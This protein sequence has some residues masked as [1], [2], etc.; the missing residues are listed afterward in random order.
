[1]PKQIIWSPL[2]EGDFAMIL[3]YLDKNWDSSVAIQFIDLT[4]KNLEQISFNPKQFP[5]IFKKERI[6]QCVLT[7][8]NSLF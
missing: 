4:E 5:L 7:K 6:R 1:M 2:S 8:H 3:E